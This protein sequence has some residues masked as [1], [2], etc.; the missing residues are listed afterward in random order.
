LNEARSGSGGGL[1]FMELRHALARLRIAF[2]VWV[3]AITGTSV[4]LYLLPRR[5]ARERRVSETP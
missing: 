1:D 4:S 2:E 5:P 3:V